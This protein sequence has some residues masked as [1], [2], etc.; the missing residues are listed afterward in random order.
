MRGLSLPWLVRLFLFAR[1]APSIDFRLPSTLTSR[2]LGR[3]LRPAALR[4]VDDRVRDARG[5]ELDRADG[6]VVAGD[7][8][9]DEIRIAVRVGDRDD[10][11][12]ELVRLLHGDRLHRR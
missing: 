8:V 2:L 1:G 10:R 11:E 3:G 6:V 12:L 4:A 5:D 9:V 7:D